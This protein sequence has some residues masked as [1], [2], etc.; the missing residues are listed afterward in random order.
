[1]E[2]WGFAMCTS[3]TFITYGTTKFPDKCLNIYVLRTSDVDMKTRVNAPHFDRIFKETHCNIPHVV[4]RKLPYRQR[5]ARYV[6]LP[7]NK[8]QWRSH[9]SLA[10]SYSRT[11]F[12]TEIFRQSAD[13][14]QD[15]WVTATPRRRTFQGRFNLR[16]HIVWHVRNRTA[17]VVWRAEFF[18][19]N[20]GSIPGATRF[21]E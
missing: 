20:S 13:M 8:Q 18:A 2:W 17:S 11:L 6:A 9:G 7:L 21:S 10:V 3:N 12:L 16:I 14:P 1:M 15:G 5:P 19:A 4:D